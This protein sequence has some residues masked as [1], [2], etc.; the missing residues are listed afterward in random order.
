MFKYSGR[1]SHAAQL[2]LR[3]YAAH[4]DR[5]TALKPLEI[6]RYFTQSPFARRKQDQHQVEEAQKEVAKRSSPGKTSLRR[7]SIEA[8]RSRTRLIINK[9]G[10]KFVDPEAET[11]VSIIAS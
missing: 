1:L 9:A 3:N 7:V 11:K 4:P 6:S 2:G 8:E 10:R 5:C